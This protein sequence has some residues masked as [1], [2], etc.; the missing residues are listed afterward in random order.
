MHGQEY[1]LLHGT[2]HIRQVGRHAATDAHHKTN[3]GRTWPIPIL[4]HPG[5]TPYGYA[6]SYQ[7]YEWDGAPGTLPGLEWT[8]LADGTNFQKSLR[9]E[10]PA[11]LKL[12][13]WPTARGAPGPTPEAE[14]W[15][16]L[17][18]AKELSTLVTH[19]LACLAAYA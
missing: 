5:T 18:L 2:E 13:L 19:E 14:K 3:D 1:P 15:G 6:K 11:T 16:T 10:G 17:Q 9:M 8:E 4:V 7:E 12:H